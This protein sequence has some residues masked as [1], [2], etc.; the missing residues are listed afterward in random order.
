[1]ASGVI[2]PSRLATS[3]SRALRGYQ[4]LITGLIS[5]L[6]LVGIMPPAPQ[7]SGEAAATIGHIANPSTLSGHRMQ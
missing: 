6:R 5:Q 2:K 7:L 3:A 4:L 1:M